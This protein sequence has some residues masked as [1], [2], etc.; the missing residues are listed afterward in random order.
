MRMPHGLAFRAGR[1]QCQPPRVICAAG[2][3]PCPI[4]RRCR[5]RLCVMPAASCFLRVQC[6][7]PRASSEVTQEAASLVMPGL[8]PGIHVLAGSQQDDVDGPGPS[9]VLSQ[10][11]R[12]ALSSAPQALAA[13][14]SSGCRRLRLPRA[15]VALE[16]Q[17]LAGDGRHHRGLEWLGDQE[18]GLRPLTG[19]ETL[20]IGGDENHRNL[21]GL[22]QL[23]HR[24]KAGGAVGEL[25]V[26]QNQAGLL[27]P[28]QCDGIGMGAGHANDV[29]AR[30]CA[31]GFRDP[32]R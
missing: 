3:S 9:L 24:I 7:F 25:D 16:E 22:Q 1:E 4:D 23:I 5:A 8:V 6:R 21:E 30:D 10:K 11:K 14:V 27:V 28:R 20:R 19:Q 18:C 26:R 12:R 15:R 2:Y 13:N 32:L 31:P 17:R 29:V